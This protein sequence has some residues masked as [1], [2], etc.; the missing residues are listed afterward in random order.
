[1]LEVATKQ[2][3]T[4]TAQLCSRSCL[5]ARQTCLNA[6]LFQVQY[7]RKQAHMPQGRRLLVSVEL[8]LRI[9]AKVAALPTVQHSSRP[10]QQLHSHSYILSNGS[11][12]VENAHYLAAICITCM[13]HRTRRFGTRG[14]DGS[15]FTHD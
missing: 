1:M 15:P 10:V 9:A 11:H 6:R 7:A 2:A 5:L 14:M 13:A 4:V 12:L 8:F 3:E